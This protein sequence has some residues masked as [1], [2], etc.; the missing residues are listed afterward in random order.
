[1]VPTSLLFED[2]ERKLAIRGLKN[3]FFN[4]QRCLYA[5]YDGIT[6]D[7]KF[8]ITTYIIPINTDLVK[9]IL[10]SSHTEYETT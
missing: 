2:K 6:L 9:Y 10:N 1:M 4:K 8:V 3:Y 7:D 5:K